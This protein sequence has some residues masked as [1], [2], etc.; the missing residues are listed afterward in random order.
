MLDRGDAAFDPLELSAGTSS[1]VGSV[2]IELVFTA[3]RLA[4]PLSVH[5]AT[6]GQARGQGGM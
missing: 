2:M 6:S 5:S 1:D 4:P 3:G